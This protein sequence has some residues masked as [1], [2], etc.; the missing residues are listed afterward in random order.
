MD[1]RMLIPIMG[2]LLVMIPV[3]GLTLAFTLR[4]AIKPF[5]ET[6]ARALRDSKSGES[7]WELAGRV[8]ELTGLVESLQTE[9]VAL[10][11][12]QSFDR[13]LLESRGDEATAAHRYKDRVRL[14]GMLIDDFHAH[15]ALPGDDIDVVVGM[16]KNEVVAF[17]Q[18]G[19]VC[20]SLGKTVTVQHHL[21]AT[22]LHSIHFD[23]GSIAPHDNGG[24]D[25]QRGS[26]HGHPLRMITGRGGDNTTLLL[27]DTHLR[28]LVV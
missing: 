17:L 11:E 2:I 8:D 7:G 27:G 14:P 28:H 21:G 1:L 13:K 19:R 4:F 24:F 12:A 25:T 22:C 18:H 26:G 6:L 20:C 3:A 23:A 5:V 15:G 10:K 9:L 16:H